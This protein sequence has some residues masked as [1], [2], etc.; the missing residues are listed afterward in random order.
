[1]HR[2]SHQPHIHFSPR[3][4]ADVDGLRAVAVL[5][6]VL[7]HASFTRFAGG[8]IGVDVFFTISGFVVTASILGDIERDD[9]SFRDFYV[10]RAKRLIPALYAM[11]FVTFAFS[12]LFCFPDDTFRLGK[13]I[14][15]VATMTSNI[16]LSKQ[17]GYFDA[18][19]S[20]QPL[21]HT[22]SLS[23]EE[24]FYVVLPLILVLLHRKARSW[25]VPCLVMLTA[26]SFISAVLQAHR[27][28]SGAYYFAQNRAFEFLIGSLLFLYES[29]RA[30]ARAWFF[31][32]IFWVGMALLVAGV[33]GLS[34]EAQFPG[35]GAIL[36]C[37]GALL[38][39]YA[40]RRSLSA[41]KVLGSA[42]AAFVGKLSYSLYL[43]HWP[44]FYALRRF[45]LA[46]PIGYAAA[47]LVASVLAL[48]TY[49][50]VEKRVKETAITGNR[51]LA[52]FLGAPILIA[53][54]VAGTGKLTDGFLFAYPAKVR[55][56]VHWSGTALFDMPRGK[57]CW[58]QVAVTD[59]ATCSLGDLASPD[60]AIL[61]GDSHAYHLVYFF[62]RLGKAHHMAIHDLAFTLCPPIE[63]E[64]ALPGYAPYLEDHL[65]CVAHD[66]AVME[67]VMS[68]PD[69]RTVFMVA[70]YQ[71]YLNLDAGPNPKPSGHGFMPG[72]LEAELGNTIQKLTAAGKR[73]VLLN[74]VPMIPMNLINC[75]FYNNLYFPVR[76]KACEFDA[77]VAEEQHQPIHEML[78]RLKAKFPQ[79]SIMHT[80]DVP[81]ANG[82]C[83]LNFD[84]LP[85]YRYNDYHHLGLAG[86]TLY[87][88][89]YAAKHPRELDQILATPVGGAN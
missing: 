83:S 66:K 42:F 52:L 50:L 20:E 76:K 77:R 86:S 69:V 78:G 35:L 1:M 48:L 29:K 33:L 8:F 6:V 32:L 57:K 63:K 49:W 54:I 3:Y 7:C 44:V 12:L 64:P 4:R 80:Y 40:G 34:A 75:E 45:D 2:T 28:S 17:T 62:D 58:S 23:V 67:Y 38:I 21:L 53:G 5:A 9:F 88:E 61:W 18:Q 70:A 24:Q 43:W 30:V 36:P 82:I 72:Q 39:M 84:G 15:A 16:Y 55:A 85:I 19:A 73:V 60:K 37:G 89:K 59:E 13:N 14:L 26:A 25:L 11:L 56:D 47:I 51:A 74:D 31:D 27:E 46:T 81:C 41:H 10:R 71:N 65:R 87:Y 79:I 22:W 68:R